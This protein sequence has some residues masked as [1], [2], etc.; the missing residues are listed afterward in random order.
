VAKPPK[1]K[2]GEADAFFFWFIPDSRLADYFVN[3]VGHLT[4]MLNE[5]VVAGSEYKRPA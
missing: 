2:I 5:F 1:I 3:S 4:W